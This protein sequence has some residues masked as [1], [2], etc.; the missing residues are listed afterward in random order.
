MAILKAVAPKKTKA[1]LIQNI[2][3]YVL[4]NEKTEEKITYGFNVD[5][6][7][8]VAQMNA[9]KDFWDKKNKG[10]EYYHFV[11]AFPPN[12]NITTEQ[13]L[14][15]AKKFIQESKAFEDF[16][17]LLATHKDKKH[18]H[19][20]FIVN[21]VSL[22]NG[23]K[24]RYSKNDLANWKE[25]QDTINIQNGFSR[26]VEKGQT[27]QGTIREETVANNRATY[28]YLKKAEKKQ[29]QSYVWDCA[30]AVLD[31]V[32][33]AKNK[34]DFMEL[35]K[36]QGFKTSWEDN[37]KHITFTDIK[38]EQNGEQKKSVRLSKLFDYFNV[39]EFETKEN[40]LNEFKRNSERTT[41][42]KQPGTNPNTTKSNTDIFDE[43]KQHRA[44][45]RNKELERIRVQ[46]ARRIAEEQQRKLEKNRNG[47]QRT[48]KNDFSIGR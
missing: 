16:E 25:L 37:K 18:I 12:E 45:E 44:D 6:K 7:N 28:E 48:D 8:C 19:T 9:T 33:K 14:E 42:T 15:M 22:T 2:C 32:H 29:V 10:R 17:V 35:M 39:Q 26:A 43:Y 47:L 40:L 21:S 3:A 4:K 36:K 46:N 38:R 23:K 30:L 31:N 11:Q 24:F 5:V 13:A 41:A 1:K 34:I 27:I 20:H